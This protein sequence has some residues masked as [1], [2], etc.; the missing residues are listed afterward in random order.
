MCSENPNRWLVF[1]SNTVGLGV[2]MMMQQASMFA[3]GSTAYDVIGLEGRIRKA[4]AEGR[5]VTLVN[6]SLYFDYQHVANVPPHINLR[7]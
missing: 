2:A 6:G 5:T 4:K 3:G 7:V 1:R